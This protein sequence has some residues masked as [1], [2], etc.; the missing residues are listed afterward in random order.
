MRPCLAF[1]GR[2]RRVLSNA[3]GGTEDSKPGKLLQFYALPH[4]QRRLQAQTQTPL[5]APRRVMDRTPTDDRQVVTETGQPMCFEADSSMGTVRLSA[6]RTLVH[7]TL[8]GDGRDRRRALGAT[9]RRRRPGGRV[10]WL[11]WWEVVG[12]GW[13]GGDGEG[14][15]D[16]ERDEGRLSKN[17]RNIPAD[18]AFP[19]PFFGAAAGFVGP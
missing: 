13:F 14:L 16:E 2:T 6:W 8:P 19:D 7:S 4:N 18:P 5:P 17:P 1:N 11:G 10:G 15:G 3:T 9:G 12:V